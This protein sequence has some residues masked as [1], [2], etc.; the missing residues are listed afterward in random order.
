VLSRLFRRLFLNA[1]GEAFQHHRL[2]FWGQIEALRDPAAFAR[3]LAPVASAEW[4][5]YAKQPF[6][7]PQKV[8]DYLGRYT[9]RV[10]ISNDRI[11]HVS[12]RRSA[13][14]GKTIA[15]KPNRNRA[16]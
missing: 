10:A 4:V 8:L 15:A 16:S 1:L 3:Y 11:L 14:S 2:Q 7:G 9:H 13:F 5:V 6:G 12:N